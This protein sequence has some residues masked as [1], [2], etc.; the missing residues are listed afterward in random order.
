MVHPFSIREYRSRIEHLAAKLEQRGLAGILLFA[1]ASVYYFTG[2]N[3]AS[4]PQLQALVVSADRRTT[5]IT[6]FSHSYLPCSLIDEVRPWGNNIKTNPAEVLW[7]I[8]EGRFGP[9]QRIGAE[10]STAILDAWSGALLEAS[11]VRKLNV[12]DAS[13]LV[14]TLR[15]TKSDAELAYVRQAAKIT[16]AAFRQA[17]N[18]CRSNAS[19]SNFLAELYRGVLSEGG[20]PV[21]GRCVYGHG[22]D[23]PSEGAAIASN[24]FNI[25]FAAAYRYYQVALTR[26]ILTDRASP[27][28]AR[29]HAAAIDALE[30]CRKTLLAG[31]TFGDVFDAHAITLDRRGYHRARL[32]A[33]GYSLGA[34]SHSSWME[35]PTACAGNSTELMPGAVVF[36]NIA[37]SDPETA[38]TMTLGE[39]YIV[40]RGA[41]ERLSSLDYS[42]IVR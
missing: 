10:Y 11:F 27:D 22:A 16:D 33:C 5:F 31:K 36:L 38:T 3:T 25:E 39:S 9:Q 15:L 29:M 34:T 21:V 32:N 24:Q 26:T 7:E 23:A 2:Y 35:S 28:Q 42:L 8:V 41:P 1:P 12:V 20:E 13:D 6:S 4:Y 40:T 17:L 18:Q 14:P 19:Q 30:A 37:L